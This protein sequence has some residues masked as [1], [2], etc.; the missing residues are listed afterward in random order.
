MAATS[1]LSAVTRGH[2]G[3]ALR[4]LKNAGGSASASPGRGRPASRATRRWRRRPGSTSRR[5]TPTAPGCGRSAAGR[6][7]C[8][9]SARNLGARRRSRR[10]PRTSAGRPAGGQGPADRGGAER[11]LRCRPPGGARRP[12]GGG[13]RGGEP[14]QVPGA[15]PDSQ[16]AVH[17]PYRGRDGPGL[18]H[19]TRR[20]GPPPGPGLARTCEP[21]RFQRHD[22]PARGERLRNLP[23]EL[24]CDRHGIAPICATARA[25]ASKPILTPPSR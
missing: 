6:P 24:R 23:R 20:P 11:A 13:A 22:R 8:R 3:A 7:R 9:G 19:P 21:R 18:A 10:W 12:S 5:T 17:D 1:E 2:R 25:A 4:A 16:R 15:K 14:L